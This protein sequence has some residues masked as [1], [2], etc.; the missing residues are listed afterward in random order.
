MSEQTKV[1]VHERLK[2]LKDLHSKAKPEM[3]IY[4]G[5]CRTAV[6]KNSMPKMRS[7][8]NGVPDLIESFDWVIDEL[9]E[10]IEK[11]EDATESLYQ[12]TQRGDLTSFDIK[13]ADQIV[14]ELRGE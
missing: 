3:E 10:H 5:H 9:F 12:L 6:D 7:V 1:N 13:L 14:N 11:L 4:K 8:C 2:E